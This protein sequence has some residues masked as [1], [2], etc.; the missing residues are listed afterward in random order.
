MSALINS[1]P[2]YSGIKFIRADWDEFG[3]SELTKELKIPRRSTLL[4]YT[5]GEEVARVIAQTN[6]D[7]IEQLFIAALQ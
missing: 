7:A 2:E 4:M 6:K 1:K 5:G 3:R